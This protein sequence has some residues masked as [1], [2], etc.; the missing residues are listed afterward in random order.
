MKLTQFWGIWRIFGWF[1][2]NSKGNCG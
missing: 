1:F 2:R